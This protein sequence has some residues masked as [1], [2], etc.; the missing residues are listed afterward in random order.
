MVVFFAFREFIGI[1][2][3]SFLERNAKCHKRHLT[4]ELRHSAPS[5]R[6]IIRYYDNYETPIP[7]P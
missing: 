6:S 5:I 4:S 1:S 7:E 2:I 3:Y